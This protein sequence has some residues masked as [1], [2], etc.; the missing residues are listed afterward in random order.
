MLHFMIN[1]N[2]VN[3]MPIVFSLV[4][5]RRSPRWECRY[6]CCISFSKCNDIL[7]GLKCIYNMSLHYCFCRLQE[8]IEISS[9]VE[10]SYTISCIFGEVWKNMQVNS[11][12]ISFIYFVVKSLLKKS[13]GMY[14]YSNYIVC[15]TG[16]QR[17]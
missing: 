16:M 8:P 9:H 13:A 4:A 17:Y 11:T 12:L 2:Y 7:C 1:F 14:E 15:H 10:V 5:K 6:S 3:L